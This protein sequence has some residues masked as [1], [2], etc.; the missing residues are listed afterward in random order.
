MLKSLYT[1]L[2]LALFLL[3]C[4]LGIS[5]LWLGAYA[6]KMY[7]QE[8]SQRLNSDLAHNIVK[9]ETLL[10]DQ[11]VN[12]Q[13]LER[14][15]HNMMVINPSIELY[16]LDPQGKILS[17]SAPEG[18]VK[19]EQISLDEIHQLLTGKHRLPLL[20][21]DP[22]DTQGNKAFSAAEIRVNNQLQG[23]LYIILGSELYENAA[24]MIKESYILRYSA[25]GIVIAAVLALGGGLLAF[26]I[27]T[28][29]L[30][31]LTDIMARYRHGQALN[32]SIAQ[33]EIPTTARDEIDELSL[34]FK[35]MA[36]RIEQQLMELKDSDAK[37]REMVANVSHDLRTP[38]TSLHGYLET[39]LLKGESLSAQER[40][41]Y[42]EIATNQ[43]QQLSRLIAELFELAK[44]DSCETLLN[45]E[46][47]SLAE[48][49][50][51]A[52]HKFQLKAKEAGINIVTQY[53]GE[54]P[55]AYGDI[56]LIQ[57]V[58]DNLIENAIRY[59]PKGG[60]ITL[61]LKPQPNNITVKVADTGS[62]IP[63]EE[64]QHIFDRFYRIQKS[65]GDNAKNAGLGL[66]I[67][68]RIILLHGSDIVAN[69]A[70]NQ[71]TIFSFDMPLRPAMG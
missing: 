56:A 63:R 64:L 15:F 69:S 5:A 32:T 6:T 37:R 71:G 8:V 28:R 70:P 65:R 61:S 55:F 24:M 52:A 53:N 46:P 59:T 40:K 25:I 36:Q 34:T 42:L 4:L 26:F 57:R 67:A 35:H 11:V 47:F 68:K 41:E 50:Q 17:Y 21:D 54:L 23:Y 9:E 31:R 22:R 43:S 30:T 48:L 51:D 60:Q 45:V 2:A 58:L 66:A 14:L 19:R 12:R 38:L 27:L 16:L 44:L 1:K 39:L 3:V 10:Q 62:G 20:G 18:K 7:Q 13:G 33:I 29:R 49:L